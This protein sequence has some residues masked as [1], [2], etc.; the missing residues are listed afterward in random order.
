MLLVVLPNQLFLLSFPQSGL[1]QNCFPLV[2][3]HTDF[4]Q[5]CWQ[6]AFWYLYLHLLPVHTL[7]TFSASYLSTS[8]VPSDLGFCMFPILYVSVSLP[9]AWPAYNEKQWYVWL[10]VVSSFFLLGSDRNEFLITSC[11]NVLPR[12]NTERSLCNLT[13]LT[14]CSVGEAIDEAG[15]V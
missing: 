6:S 11:N 8:L 1:V 3:F 14:W 2:T 4:V 9:C 10:N 7:C 13:Y 5:A 12:E 15:D